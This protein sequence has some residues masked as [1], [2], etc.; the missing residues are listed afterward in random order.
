MRVTPL[1]SSLPACCSDC[2]A[3]AALWLKEATACSIV[4]PSVVP[5][6]P[7]AST[8]VAMLLPNAFEVACAESLQA[9]EAAVSCICRSWPAPRSTPATSSA[10]LTSVPA[11]ACRRSD[12]SVSA[13]RSSPISWR[14]DCWIRPAWSRIIC[15]SACWF[16]AEIWPVRP[17]R[18]ATMR[19]LIASISGTMEALIERPRCS[20]T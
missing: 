7:S 5:A 6:R 15:S 18:L 17:S 14:V 11:E 13:A 12:I 20:A 19:R 3:C 16:I 10:P 4:L 9:R 1:S 8:E 2:V